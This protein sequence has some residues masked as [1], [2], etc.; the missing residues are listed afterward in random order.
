MCDGAIS[1]VVFGAC[2]RVR[3]I[4]SIGGGWA[5]VVHAHNALLGFLKDSITNRLIQEQ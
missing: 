1:L 3:L 2:D 5:V 4:Y